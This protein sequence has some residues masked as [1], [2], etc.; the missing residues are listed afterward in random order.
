MMTQRIESCLFLEQSPSAPR[1]ALTN[2]MEI[3][4]LKTTLLSSAVVATLTVGFAPSSSAAPI[5]G[6]F[7]PQIDNG[8]QTVQWR[9]CWWEDGRRVCRFRERGF[10]YGDWDGWHRWRRWRHYD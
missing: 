10:G 6:T 1:S 2:A 4:M 8:I 3:K 9:R 7:A 5:V